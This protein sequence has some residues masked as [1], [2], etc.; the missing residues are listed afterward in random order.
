MSD[1]PLITHLYTADPSAHAFEGKIYLY[2]SHDRDSGIP[3]NDNGDQYDMVDYHVFS[4]E[5]VCGPV[6]D[7]GVVLA[8]KDVPWASK[9]LWAPDAAHKNGRYYLYFPARDQAGVFRIGVAISDRP[10]GPFRPEPQPIAGSYSID[11]C[12]FVDDDGKSYL[13]FGGI[14]GG[15]LQ[16]WRTGRFDPEGREPAAGDP[17]I[18]PRVA[19]LADDMKS[20]DGGVTEIK[21][22]DESGQPLRAGDHDRRY[23]EAPWLHKHNGVYYFSYSTG[24]THYLVYATGTNPRGPFTYQGR[25]LEPV[26]GWTTH[27]SIVD[28]KGRTYLFHHDSSLSGG[29]SHL[30]CVKVKEL[31]YDA[32]GRITGVRPV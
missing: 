7:H 27:H 24:D 26:I 9:Q 22:L 16:K 11:P 2:P 10:S 19:A 6:T 14:W 18:G 1:A 8:L 21:I 17:A 31:V 20:F 4:M 12:C 13:Y 28:Y 23:F 5:T 3:D 15:Q 25:I 29:K 32:E 30:R